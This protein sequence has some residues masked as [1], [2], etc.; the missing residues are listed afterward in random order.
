VYTNASDR[1]ATTIPR[2][3]IWT[4]TRIII[5]SLPHSP[6]QSLATMSNFFTDAIIPSS[7]VTP[8][9]VP[10]TQVVINTTT[11]NVQLSSPKNLYNF[12]IPF[13]PH[14]P[15]ENTSN[16]PI[17]LQT[18]YNLITICETHALGSGYHHTEFRY[19]LIMMWQEMERT[20]QITNTSGFRLTAEMFQGLFIEIINEMC[21]RLRFYGVQ[22]REMIIPRDGGLI[23]V[24]DYDGGILGVSYPVEVS[25]LR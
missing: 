18:F 7:I 20:Y 16:L 8:Q 12:N 19:R 2:Q 23:K 3:Y 10:L 11:N 22:L 24:I 15:G 5:H 13:L 9:L 6:T 21:R 17:A 14:L 4:R 1:G 25:S